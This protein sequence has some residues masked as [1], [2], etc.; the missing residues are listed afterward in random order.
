LKIA[1]RSAGLILRTAA[2]P[3]HVQGLLGSVRVYEQPLYSIL[4]YSSARGRYPWVVRLRTQL[5]PRQVRC[6]SWHD[7]VTVHEVFARRDYAVG[8]APATMLDCGAN[9]GV[10]ALWALTLRPDAE[11]H[12]VE[13]VEP[14]V[15]ELSRNLAGLEDRYSVETTAVAGEAGEV[16]FGLEPSGR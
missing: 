4:R 9:I 11:V 1:G 13:P 6:R 12:C 8:S 2:D 15:T 3:A 16:D 10:T 5:G 14:N 7:L